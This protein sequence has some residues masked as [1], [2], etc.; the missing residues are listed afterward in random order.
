MPTT[1]SCDK[2]GA[3]WP[4]DDT[5]GSCPSCSAPTAVY[6]PGD[7][8]ATSDDQTRTLSLSDTPARAGAPAEPARSFGD[9]EIIGEIARGGMGVVYKARQ[10]SLNRLVALKMIRS[11][12]LASEGEVQRFLDEAEIAAG[13]DHPNLVPIYEV[14]EHEGQHFFSMKLVEGGSLAGFRG[15]APADRDYQR[16]VARIVAAVAHAVHHAHQRGLLH[17]DLKPGNVLLDNEGTPHVT[18]FGL[19]K[20]VGGDSGVTQSGA[21]VGTP[22]YMAPE[23]AM[24]TRALTTAADVYG[25]G[26]VLYDL[27][28]GRPPFLGASP[29]DTLQQVLHTEPVPPRVHDRAIDRDLETVC[30]KCLR[31]DRAGR[32]PSAEAL[33]EDLE[34]W[35]GGEPVRA[36]SVGR[37]ERLVKWARRRPAAA[38]LVAVVAVALVALLGGGVYYNRELEAR[39]ADIRTQLRRALDAEKVAREAEQA[40]KD[41]ELAA[42]EAGRVAKE[43]GDRLQDALRLTRRQRFNT[44]VMR[45][46]DIAMTEPTLAQHLLEDEDACPPELRDFS[47]GLFHRLSKPGERSFRGQSG[48][49]TVLAWSADGRSVFS[50]SVVSVDFKTGK[51]T[52][53]SVVEWD[54]ATGDRVRTFQPDTTVGAPIGAVSPDGKTAAV[55]DRKTGAALWGLATGREVG[56]LPGNLTL[57]DR[58]A[59]SADGSTVVAGTRDGTLRAWDAATRQP[60]APL[61][62]HKGGVL[63]LS[64]SADGR[65]LAAAGGASVIDKVQFG[66]VRVWDMTTGKEVASFDVPA[67]AV[68]SVA[69]SRDGRLLAAGLGKDIQLWDVPARTPLRVLR[70][71]EIGVSA[72]SFSPDG[73]ALASGGMDRTARL[74][75]VATGRLVSSLRDRTWRVSAIAFSPDGGT[76]AV[77]SDGLGDAP[78]VLLWDVDRGAVRLTLERQYTTAS[79]GNMA[80]GD[81]GW[82]VVGAGGLTAPNNIKLWDA[83]TGKVL[84]ALPEPAMEVRSAAL[85][86]DGKLLALGGE[87]PA[88]DGTFHGFV[89]LIDVPTRAAGARLGGH[90]RAVVGLAFS[91]DGKLLA[92]G[93][94]VGSVKLWDV[95]A[96]KESVPLGRHDVTF[97]SLVFSLDGRTLITG[98]GSDHQRSEIKLWDVATGAVR[99]TITDD[100]GVL[101]AVAITPDGKTLISTSGKVKQSGKV[102]LWDA[103]TG[104]LRV[105]LE[106]H[107]AF[108]TCLAVSPDGQTLASGSND[109]TIRL[110]DPVAGQER[111]VLRVQDGSVWALAFVAGGKVLA[112]LDRTVKLWDGSRGR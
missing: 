48:D 69:L 96:E 72:L 31:K 100:E 42:T 101:A 89:Q 60:R 86:P 66:E 71:H 29:L 92:S 46:A 37:A 45:A 50:G 10:V 18:D 84:A 4:A 108:V 27:L 57:V 82:V 98:A 34:R 5:P 77:G 12:A 74:W 95:A 19:A 9:Y 105:S 38:A 21:V 17:R 80:V 43:R 63:A 78:S 22:S 51:A 62:K 35:L 73:R 94:M 49:V 79:V 64:L 67:A 68:P 24:A 56:S 14:G 99:L 28:T 104:K 81:G 40:A 61:G 6:R 59:W 109:G 25:L 52:P 75:D 70:G 111:G 1:V 103:A 8:Q 7:P 55:V 26:A 32:Y 107:T 91:P 16:R 87:E 39:N 58:M 85:S 54:A 93:D 112:S 88:G 44:Q 76:V 36:R 53:G 90:D 83:A 3:T 110:W 47:W 11:Q 20:R 13:L 15:A 30:L 33:A 2:C 97:R 102:K 65:L 41:A 23:Q 106:G